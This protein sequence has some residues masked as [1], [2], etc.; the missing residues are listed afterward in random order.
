MASQCPNC[1]KEKEDRLKFCGRSCALKWRIK[2]GYSPY[3]TMTAET[4]ARVKR[5]FIAG[6]VRFRQENPDFRR[7]EM[8][9]NNPMFKAKTR[10][11]L[12]TTLKRIGHKPPIQGGN[13]RGPTEPERKILTAFPNAKWNYAVSSGAGART[14]GEASC[15]KIDIAWP[16]QMVALEVDGSSH[17]LRSRQEQDRKKERILKSKG[18]SVFR[19][20]NKTLRKAVDIRSTI[21]QLVG[22]PRILPEEF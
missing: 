22:T 20:S 7:K 8:T 21:C 16:T 1:G 4:R 15:Y 9:E 2:N 14:R 17:N 11:K 13:G 6:G 10:Q 5:L 3:L 19:I 12:R 18:W